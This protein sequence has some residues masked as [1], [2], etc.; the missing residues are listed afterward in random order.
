MP[1]SVYQD[2]RY[3]PLDSYWNFN[4]DNLE[5]VYYK[6]VYMGCLRMV[7]YIYSMSK[8]NGDLIV[9]GGSQGGL[10]SLVTAALDDR[11]M[12]CVVFYPALADVNGYLHGHI[13]LRRKIM[14]MLL[15]EEKKRLLLI[16]ML[17]T[18]QG[19]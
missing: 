10:L 18:L 9:Y 7:D 4:W 2:L 5:T 11:V 15:S 17:S 8:F 12:G 1:A 19:Y 6:R 13:I 3:G 14:Q 16:M